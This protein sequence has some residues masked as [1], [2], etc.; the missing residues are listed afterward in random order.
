[1]LINKTTI[2]MLSTVPVDLWTRRNHIGV[3]RRLEAGMCLY[4][5]DIDH[6]TTPVEAGLSWLVA[7]RRRTTA[8][9]P[10]AT[11]I[12]DQLRNG[13]RRKRVGLKSK[14]PS[15][16][17]GATVYAMTDASDDDIVG[18][19]TSGCPSPSL[20]GNIAMGYVRSELAKSGTKVLLAV[21]DKH[22]EATVCTLPFVPSKYY[23]RRAT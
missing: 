11:V 5:N 10:G 9:F 16:R 8:D 17:A 21:R 6:T 19:V 22:V 4:G 12:I 2:Y 13:P 1:M 18:Y 14:G 3:I 23:V 15:A 7:K 20:G